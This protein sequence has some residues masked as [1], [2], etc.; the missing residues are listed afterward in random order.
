MSTT[1]IGGGYFDHGIERMYPRES[2]VERQLPRHEA[3][4][5]P[6]GARVRRHLDE[7]L[8]APGLETR[9]MPG[10]AER[11]WDPR[12]TLPG[13]YRQNLDDTEQQ[14]RQHAEDSDGER[15][16]IFRAAADIVAEER[17]RLGLLD[18]YRHALHAG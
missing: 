15:G 3:P 18:T 17:A 6:A 16:A 8:D 4:L 7:V 13:A 5:L 12:L 10:F 1:P 14:L 9:L 2:Q 11:R